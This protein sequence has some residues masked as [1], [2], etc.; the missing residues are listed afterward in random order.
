MATIT[1]E[2]PDDPSNIP[3]AIKRLNE[4]IATARAHLDGLRA[5]KEAI[6][7]I[8]KHPGMYRG[9]DIGGGPDGYCS[10]CEY[11]Y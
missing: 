1:I 11:S 3:A 10:I 8:C 5:A 6:Q 9:T 4:Q 2:I 7:R